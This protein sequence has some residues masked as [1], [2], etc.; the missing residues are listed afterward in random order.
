MRRTLALFFLLFTTVTFS[1]GIAVDTTSLSIPQLVK[2]VLMQNSCSNEAN[3]VFSS[4][5]GIGQFTNTNPNFPFSNG[6]IMRNGIAKNTEGPYTATN[7]SSQ[8]STA[9][10]PDLQAIS[11][12]NGQTAAITDVSFIQFDFTPLSNNFSF[13][14]VF[15]SNEYGQ[16][17]CS[18]SDVFAF[19]L[20]DLTTG[21]TSNLAVIPSTTIPV[22][23][24]NIRDAAN[25]PAC[26]STN[27][28]YFSS[29]NVTNPG[30]S[31][32]NM[33]G[34]TK[35]L[36]ATSPVVPNRTYRIKL[37]I[38]DYN[39]S[40]YDTAV[41]IKGGSFTTTTDLG[42]DT[43]ICQ[44]ENIILDSGL[45]TDF[46]FAW[47]L[48]NTVIP[49]ENNATLVVSQAGTYGLVAT[50]SGCMITDE[51]V[52]SDL[53]LSTPYNLS[54]CNTGQATYPFDL[55][56]NNITTLGLDPAEYAVLYYDSITSANSNGASI[57]A[58]Q[59]TAY[60]SAGNQTIYMKVVHLSNNNAV[61]SNLLSFDLVVNSGVI[62][63]TPPDLKLCNNDSGDIMA[64]LTLQ[65][66]LILNGQNPNDFHISYFKSQTDAQD[67][68]NVIAN[69]D[70]FSTTIAD[71]PQAIWARIEDA[72]NPSC[73]AIVSFSILV[74]PHP[75]VDAIP[76]V[77]ECSSYTLPAI[78]NGNY[79]TGPN[80]TGVLLHAGDILTKGGTYYIFNGPITPNGCT[81]ESTF[82]VQFI[83][84][85]IISDTACGKYIV[86]S[87]PAGDFF[88][89][90]G[91]TGNLI[92]VGTE[93]TTDQTIYF[94]AVID[95]SVC[96]D[97]PINITIFPLP[98]VDDPA[99]V[100]TCNS[101]TLPP[102]VNG[103]YFTGS[104]G[105]GS[106]LNA[107]TVLNLSQDVFVFADNGNCSAE[108][109]FRI[110]IVDT[111]IYKTITAC[112]SYTL[113]KI[114]FGNYYTQPFGSGTIIPA[115]TEIT[116]S[117]S[118]YYYAI[119]TTSPNCTDNLNYTINIKPLPPVDTPVD[120]LECGSYVLPALTNGNYFT[121]KNGGGTPLFAGDVITTTQN[122]YV[123]ALG[124][125]NC[126]NEHHF[127]VTIRPLPPVDTFI[128]AFTCTTFTLPPLTN[129][130][131]Y[132]ASGGPNGAGSLIPVGTVI[133]TTQTIFIYNAWADFP[134]CYNE[135]FFVVEASGVE[136]GTFDDV[137]ACDSYTLP[138]LT[139][140]DYY[141][142]PNGQGAIIPAGTVLTSSQ[143]I[144]VFASAGT[145][146]T[147][148]DEDDFIVNIS[149]T[150]VL[151]DQPDVANCVS[152]TLPNLVLGNYFSGPNGSGTPYSAGDIISTSQT[153]YV[154]EASATNPDCF[155]QKEFEITIYPLK[156]LQMENGVICVDPITEDLLSPAF[157]N[158]GLNPA[159]YT[160]DWY[161]NQVLVGT[162]T[163]YLATQDGAYDLAITKNTVNIGDDC[164]YNNATVIVEKSSKAVAT[165]TVTGAFLDDIA[166]IVNVTKGFGDYEYQLDQG[167]FQNEPVFNDVASGTH[168]ITIH[169]RK[170]DCENI[171]LT[172]N[173]LKYPKFFT[174]NG[175]GFNDT[176]NIWD[177]SN[178]PG[179]MIQI[180]DRYGKFIK[181]I[182]PSGEGWDGT[183]NGKMLPSTDY[184]FHVKYSIDNM[185]QEFKSHFSMKR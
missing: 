150:P 17:Q 13:D 56:Q 153:M 96:R 175:D 81:N 20:T 68:T 172:A 87:T 136:V 120:R 91:G 61:C 140:G 104:G 52:I 115:G 78:V 133:S 111:S 50:H 65:N 122:I 152:Y 86:R 44:G 66:G 101:Y 55:T 45:G 40:N 161:L 83:D 100:V 176:W 36:T 4:H 94:Y 32:I 146:L 7:E 180:F 117:Q 123:Y 179:A 34:E 185:N 112:G 183:S 21:T 79:Y 171:V 184:W 90:P 53:P 138:S 160:V 38:G 67:K 128:D 134:T 24:K 22:S 99:D 178:Q 144:Y 35:L 109:V 73:F 60:A 26:L 121:G 15:A 158:T 70:A 64:D 33:R 110:D 168:S 29:Y 106:S 31:A 131:Y 71:S 89:G 147:C 166:I 164:G 74:F 47:T 143:T 116:S 169:D 23:V 2:N 155:A 137:N 6:L 88:T 42:K 107:G 124:S 103:K 127:K 5:L 58:S 37:A 125:N 113:P 18:F 14:F 151:T 63:N 129:G 156:D 10:D 62:A 49:G 157:L 54:F 72:V 95:G 27:P 57:P 43:T 177:L 154:Y 167:Q 48:N 93:L 76:A 159:V 51:I 46:T 77:I 11:N 12:S 130:Q 174:P 163:S 19:L 105:S 98:L 39:D 182:T 139:V 142:Q 3:F 126:D 141:S 30:T 59:L 85:L 28:N 162:G 1:Q 181:Q 119:T 80:G 145:R 132:T 170:G 84:E 97:E 114:P 148:T 41:F 108:N 69:P 149:V 165:L 102:L 8:V 135:S 118:V 92:P 75:V 16:Y 82:S 173:V 9:G 25:N